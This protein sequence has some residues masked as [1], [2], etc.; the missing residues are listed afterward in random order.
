MKEGFHHHHLPHTS[1]ATLQWIAIACTALGLVISTYYNAYTL[2]A[3]RVDGELTSYLHLN[4][5]YH[6]L[7]FTLMDHDSGIFKKQDDFD[8][9]KNKYIIYELF[10]LFATID[11]LEHYFTELDKDVW[12]CWKRRMEFLFSKPAI[13]HA[14][15]CHAVYADQIYKPEFV[16]RVESVIA[17]TT[18]LASS[19]AHPNPEN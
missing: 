7:L 19:Q 11:S 13:R 15:Q 17:S 4:D 8:L 9:Q 1:E 16:K 10:E 18:P 2:K 14:W 6:K 5:R 12:P 3:E